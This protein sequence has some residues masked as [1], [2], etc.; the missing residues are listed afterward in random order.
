MGCTQSKATSG[1]VA[2]PNTAIKGTTTKDSPLASNPAAEEPELT[3]TRT[4]SSDEHEVAT[5]AN[6]QAEE[7]EQAKCTNEISTTPLTNE[8]EAAITAVSSKEDVPFDEPPKS[9]KSPRRR[10]RRSNS[11]G[12]RDMAVQ[13]EEIPQEVVM[14]PALQPVVVK[15][16]EAPA[17]TQEVVEKKE[18]EMPVSDTE[19][20]EEDAA[21]SP[22]PVAVQKEP[23][24]TA[25]S[26][27]S[28]KVV[29]ETEANEEVQKDKICAGC[30]VSETTPGMFKFCARCKVVSYCGRDC[31]ITH[32]SQHKKI[33][34]S[35]VE[36][37]N[38]SHLM[39]AW[40]PTEDVSDEAN[41]STSSS[42][43]NEAVKELEEV[44][45]RLRS[46]DPE[47]QDEDN[48]D[49]VEKK[50]AVKDTTVEASDP[51]EEAREAV[52]VVAE[53]PAVDENTAPAAPQPSSSDE[54]TPI[55][56]PQIKTCAGCNSEE[57]APGAF[58]SC[59]KC[60]EVFYCD[61]SCQKKHFKKHKKTCCK[62]DSR[63]SLQVN[64]DASLNPIKA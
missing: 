42:V 26:E 15:K 58:K 16:V 63:R 53:A 45:Q 54:N 57:K 55:S 36:H 7:P 41:E 44:L 14:A 24:E 48:E 64:K 19:A 6:K 1:A 17:P 39:E 27:D 28:P 5:A 11:S 3:A 56:L 34:S 61:R 59:A 20:T 51:V 32:W 10:R 29:E 8:E 31:Q 18:K 38:S 49:V 22:Q 62:T 30:D 43:H 60:R 47:L 35:L 21:K 37:A 12:V 23:V 13:E 9:P 4:A 52:Q 40:N 33:C 2:D 50:D 25:S 46:E